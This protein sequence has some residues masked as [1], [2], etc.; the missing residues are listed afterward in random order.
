MTF[1]AQKDISI[2]HSTGEYLTILAGT[3]LDSTQLL[4]ESLDFHL[5]QKNLKPK[6]IADAPKIAQDGNPDIPAVE[7]KKSK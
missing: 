6:P 5:E 3:E 1:I 4:S 7:V 2:Q